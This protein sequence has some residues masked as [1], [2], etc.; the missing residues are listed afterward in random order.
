MYIKKFAKSNLKLRDTAV[1]SCSIHQCVSVKG[2]GKT[3][4]KR[5][6]FLS[7]RIHLRG[8]CDFRGRFSFSWSI[9]VLE[10]IVKRTRREMKEES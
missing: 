3:R 10:V 1:D 5:R 6:T 2:E 9:R 8:E 7:I 4:K